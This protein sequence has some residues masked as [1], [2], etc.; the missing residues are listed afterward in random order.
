MSWCPYN[1]AN[2]FRAVNK[3]LDKP[4]Q[5]DKKQRTILSLLSQPSFLQHLNVKRRRKEVLL[6]G[7][8]GRTKMENWEWKRWQIS[9]TSRGS[10]GRKGWFWNVRGKGGDA[11]RDSKGGKKQVQTDCG[12]GW[13]LGMGLS[14]APRVIDQRWASIILLHLLGLGKAGVLP[15]NKFF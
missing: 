14:S 2:I 7:R 13:Q 4:G 1:I 3:I 11:Q 9:W 8:Q 6:R 12:K 15:L 5:Q 10:R